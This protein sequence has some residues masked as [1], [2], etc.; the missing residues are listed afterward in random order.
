MQRAV[1]EVADKACNGPATF[2]WHHII[3]YHL[4]TWLDGAAIRPHL[5]TCTLLHGT[6]H[7]ISN[8]QQENGAVN[9]VPTAMV[10]LKWCLIFP[11]KWAFCRAGFTASKK[12]LAPTLHYIHVLGLTLDDIR[13]FGNGASTC[14]RR[15]SE[16]STW[17][18]V[19]SKYVLAYALLYTLCP[20]IE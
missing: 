1:G 14:K 2:C 10:G 6:Q 5:A 16:T 7:F 3:P 4:C 11:I 12:L 18:T 13:A 19:F 17:Y 8:L 15:T 9:T 20:S